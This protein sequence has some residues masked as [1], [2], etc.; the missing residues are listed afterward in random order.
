MDFGQSGSLKNWVF[1]IFWVLVISAPV[2][3]QEKPKLEMEF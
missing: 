1:G 2:M 3:G